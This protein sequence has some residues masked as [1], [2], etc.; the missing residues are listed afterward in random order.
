[1]RHFLE[2]EIKLLLWNNHSKNKVYHV[3]ATDS[4]KTE[5]NYWLNNLP[6]GDRRRKTF[7][8]TLLLVLLL[9]L[10]T[11]KQCLFIYLYGRFDIFSLLALVVPMI[12]IFIMRELLLSHRLGYQLLPI[13]S[14]VALFRPENKIVPDIYMYL[15]MAVLSAFLYLVLFPK[16]ERMLSQIN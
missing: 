15:F 1:M 10:L 12:N 11:V 5:L 13:L 7:P 9:A 6:P 8:I 16:S 3:L 14:I 2:K 4:N